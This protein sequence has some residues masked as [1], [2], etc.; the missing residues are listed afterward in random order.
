MNWLAP[1]KGAIFSLIYFFWIYYI[2]HNYVIPQAM[3]HAIPQ[4]HSL[5]SNGKKMFRRILSYNFGCKE[6][7]L[8][9]NLQDKLMLTWLRIFRDTL[10]SILVASV[11]VSQNYIYFWLLV[12]SLASLIAVP[13]V[14]SRTV[15]GLWSG[16]FYFCDEIFGKKIRLQYKR[17][18]PSVYWSVCL[19]ELDSRFSWC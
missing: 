3:P 7:A 14:F 16:R 18:F 2:P 10:I 15:C 9:L 4:T 17:N 6:K 12:A 5:T 19:F 1:K 11:S 13:F 8:N